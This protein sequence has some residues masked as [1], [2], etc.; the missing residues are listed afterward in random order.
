MPGDAVLL[1]PG[2]VLVSR[3]DVPLDGAA[4]GQV[5]V[6]SRYTA[7]DQCQP[8]YV[9]V[10]AL[11][12]GAWGRVF[13]A[14]GDGLP[15]GPL[16]SQPSRGATSCYPQLRLFS[17][18]GSGDGRGLL[19]VGTGYEDTS[20]RILVLGWDAAKD[21]PVP[22]FDRRTGP[23]GRF[24]RSVSGDRI[25]IS[26]DVAAGTDEPAVV[27]RFTQTITLSGYTAAVTGHR[28]APNCDRGR[29]ASTPE[30]P[31]SQ[32]R[33]L[34]LTCGDGSQMAV[35]VDGSTTLQPNGASWAD[36]EAQDYV[37]IDFD[38]NSLTP[39]S[40]AAGVPLATSVSDTAAV[41]RHAA[42][43]RAV[44]RPTQPAAPSRSSSAP[45]Q[46]GAPAAAPRPATT[47]S[48]PGAAPARSNP[49]ATVQSRPPSG[50]SSG[51]SGPPPLPTLPRPA[52]SPPPAPRNPPFAGPPPSA[53]R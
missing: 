3:L 31:S 37:Q 26:E 28:F 9:D 51:S 11:R 8:E 32:S 48:A 34:R 49:A 13:A 22:L 19:L 46:P 1:R 21:R 33:L 4:P 5:A 30:P 2:A 35:R 42:A 17:G 53:P 12:D 39:E 38:P 10:F 6:R 20:V 40:A 25:D 18:Q 47:G 36:V 45:A 29:L 24:D 23:N 52:V 50:A 15:N 14:D 7:T 27:G 43:Q 16:L 44:A 41:A